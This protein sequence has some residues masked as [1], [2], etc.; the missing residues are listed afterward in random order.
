MVWKLREWKNGNPQD[1]LDECRRLG[2]RWI[3]IKDQDGELARWEGSLARQNA[4]LIPVT[5]P[6]LAN[7]GIH[8][9]GTVWLYG[10]TRTLNR[11]WSVVEAD[12]TI[13]IAQALRNIGVEPVL[14]VNAEGYYKTT[15]LR[16]NM[17]DLARVYCQR[18]RMGVPDIQLILDTYKFPSIHSTFPFSRFMESCVGN[19]PEE[20]WLGETALNAGVATLDRSLV[21]YAAIRVLPTVPIA[22]TYPYGLGDGTT[23]TAGPLQLTNFFQRAVTKGCQG[24]GIWRLETATPGQ[25]DAIAAFPWPGPVPQPIPFEDLPEPERWGIV[26]RDLRTRGIVD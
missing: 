21:E 24:A 10:R 7:A 15:A 26:G 19:A 12:A 17:G 8:V 5:V 13:A 11:D 6:V 16:P 18:V 14:L 20:Y 25:K 2:L 22:P 1:Q 3:S 4:D 23:W 9:S